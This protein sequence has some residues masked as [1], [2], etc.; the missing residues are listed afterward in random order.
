MIKALPRWMGL[1]SA[2]LQ[3]SSATLR[4]LLSTIESAT[5]ALPLPECITLDNPQDTNS[6]HNRRTQRRGKTS[7]TPRSITP[8]RKECSFIA[9]W[10][11]CQAQRRRKRIQR[12]EVLCRQGG[13]LHRQ[14]ELAL[15]PA[16]SQTSPTR[17]STT[18]P[19]SVCSS[20]IWARPQLGIIANE[21]NAQN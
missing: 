2:N 5:V 20:P 6:K 18:P 9:N 10:A 19:R 1:L 11:C 15:S 17:R 3:Q 7:S 21:S 4:C 13:S 8:P 12:A 16:S 14:F